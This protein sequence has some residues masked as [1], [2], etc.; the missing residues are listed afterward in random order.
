MKTILIV[1]ALLAACV[2]F[3]VTRRILQMHSQYPNPTLIAFCTAAIGFLG[4]LGFGVD[5]I[6]I[7]VLPFIGLALAF[8]LLFIFS[9]L[10][11]RNRRGRWSWLGAIGEFPHPRQPPGSPPPINQRAEQHKSNHKSPNKKTSYECLATKS[12]RHAR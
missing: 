1:I 4:L 10:C 3:V 9:C 8:L 2:T 11:R 5:V 12:Y 7:V 6:F